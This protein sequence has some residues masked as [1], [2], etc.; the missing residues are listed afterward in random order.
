MGRWVT[1]RQQSSASLAPPR[2]RVGLVSRY[3]DPKEGRSQ[4]SL[5]LRTP[6]WVWRQLDQIN[7]HPVCARMALHVKLFQS[8][9]TL[10][11]PMDCSPSSSSVSGIFPARVLEWVAMPFS[12]GSA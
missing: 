6:V 4:P 2:A 8:C 7:P 12:R 5:V 3:R 9:P 10:C 11:D 1:D